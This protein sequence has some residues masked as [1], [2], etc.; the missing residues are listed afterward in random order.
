MSISVS[1]VIQS[2]IKKSVVGPVGLPFDS[3]DYAQPTGY[4]TPPKSLRTGFWPG[5]HIQQ[6]SFAGGCGSFG[7]SP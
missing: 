3:A 7:L 4:G 6:T 2:I 5:G 1:M